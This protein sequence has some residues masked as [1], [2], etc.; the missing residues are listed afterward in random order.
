MIE[1]PKEK[2]FI[3]RD[4][5]TFLDSKELKNGQCPHCGSDA[6]FLNDVED[7]G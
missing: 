5:N 6:V 2:E 1:K 4:C 7:E 3:C